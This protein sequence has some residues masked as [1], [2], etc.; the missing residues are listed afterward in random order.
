MTAHHMPATDP[1]P[2]ISCSLASVSAAG[3]AKQH[4]KMLWMSLE[5]GQPKTIENKEKKQ[6]SL[7]G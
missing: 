2:Y 7:L 5:L 6:T 4:L 3:M 1:V